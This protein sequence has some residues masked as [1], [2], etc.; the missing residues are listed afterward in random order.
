MDD[1]KK[2]QCAHT[3]C[4]CLVGND[5]RYCIPHCGASLISSLSNSAVMEIADVDSDHLHGAFAMAMNIAAYGIYSR[6]IAL[7]DIVR[8]LNQTR[9]ENESICM[10]LSPEH[11]IAS[12]IRGASLFNA[13]RESS[14]VTTKLLG[15]L[16]EFGAVMIP[17]VVFFIRSQAFFHALMFARDAPAL[18]GNARTLVGLDLTEREAER[19]E[20][21]LD[22]LGVLVYISCANG[23]R[24]AAARRSKGSGY[25]GR[26]HECR[27][28]G[29]IRLQG[30]PHRAERSRPRYAHGLFPR[31]RAHN[32]DNNKTYCEASLASPLS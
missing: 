31:L 9:F 2:N 28:S 18:C 20:D 3:G 16:S 12:M 4:S 21:Q 5:G 11:P 29:L 10:V 27:S 25:A 14:A 7:A 17:T 19:Y 26:E 22:R 30:L 24:S 32:R 13:E 8:N 15:W 6:D 1:K 23:A